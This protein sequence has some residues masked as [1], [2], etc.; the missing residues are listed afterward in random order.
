MSSADAKVSLQ[1]S[2]FESVSA[3]TFAFGSSVFEIVVTGFFETYRL[4]WID[5]VINPTPGF[6]DWRIAFIGNKHGK[7][8]RTWR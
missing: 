8:L 2:A 6:R 4:T 7:A 5:R 3:F 1:Q